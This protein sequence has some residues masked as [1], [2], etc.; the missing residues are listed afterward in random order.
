MNNALYQQ[1]M[2]SIKQKIVQGEL[3]IGDKLDSERKMA[4]MYGIN[5]MTVRNAIKNL[6]KEGIVHSYHGKG[7]FV[8]KI[9]TVSDK[10]Q[11]G[12]SENL[13]L[14]VQIRQKGMSSS[15]KVI[16][17]SVVDVPK[18]ATEFF[19]CTKVYELIRLFTI[20]EEPYALQKTYVPY[21]LFMDMERFDFESNS[22]YEY[23]ADHGHQTI[24]QTSELQITT[25]PETYQEMMDVYPED[26]LFLFQYYGYDTNHAHVEYTTSYNKPKYTCFQFVQDHSKER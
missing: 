9:P 1:L 7:T 25:L 26:Q 14:S 5:R 12:D 2:Q 17:L 3:Q 15:K 16:S 8:E 6:E 21:D 18:E 23:M 19:S 22:L 20:N 11:L 13:S 24:T 4:E 10:L